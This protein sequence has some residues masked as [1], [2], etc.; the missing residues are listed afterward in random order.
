MAEWF[1]PLSNCRGS[2]PSGE[3]LGPTS[4]IGSMVFE[5][6]RFV[7]VLSACRNRDR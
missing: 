7:S 5:K 6:K 1:S 2:S 3:N 4:R